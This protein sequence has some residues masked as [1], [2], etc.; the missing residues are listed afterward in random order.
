MKIFKTLTKFEWTL[1]L[2]SISAVIFAFF[3]TE[4]FNILSLIASLIGVFALTF[5]A[6]GYVLGQILTVFFSL[7]YAVISFELKYYGEMI[8]YLCMTAPIATMSVISWIKN[9][10]TKGEPEVAVAQL[11]KR[12]I[13][14]MIILATFVTFIFYY[15]LKYLGNASIFFSCLS[16]TTS[17][18]ASYLMY[19]RSNWYA[20]AYACN[21]IVLI[22]LWVIAT[23]INSQY[24]TM[25]IC[26]TAF[27]VNDL[28]A[29]HNWNKMKKRQ[30]KNST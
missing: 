3:I 16:I 14:T 2:T 22:C 13:A 12:K 21:D 20:V 26:F 9:P 29:Y 27:L 1:M 8:T 10:Y 4:D 17:F 6:K 15:I 11:D 24:L 5:L 25:V 23:F 7:I 30:T 18:C 28:Y 19:Q